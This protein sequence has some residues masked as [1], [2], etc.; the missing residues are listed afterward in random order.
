M[1]AAETV[2]PI[3][4][5]VVVQATNLLTKGREYRVYARI[6]G[7]YRLV[8]GPFGI[9]LEAEQVAAGWRTASG[10]RALGQAIKDSLRGMEGQ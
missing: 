6:E 10:W 1:M 3:D 5:V 2:S 4:R 9:L 7:D 8:A